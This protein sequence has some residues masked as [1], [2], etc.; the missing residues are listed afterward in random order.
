M[1]KEFVSDLRRVPPLERAQG[2]MARMLAMTTAGAVLSPALPRRPGSYTRTCA[3]SDD[4]F[5]VLLLD[6]SP[7]AVSAIHDHGGQHC[8]F[9]V[10]E[11]RLRVD[12]FDRLDSGDVPGRAIVEARDWRAL[13]PGELD[14]RS[15]P[16][17]IHRVAADAGHAVSLHVYARPLHGFSIYDERAHRCQSVRGTYDQLLSLFE[18][19]ATAR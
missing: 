17:D 19:S 6:W 11:G 18:G 1:L 16:F 10:L 5:E 15:G 3:Y 8:W 4:R 9:V 13:G 2:D 7:G 12:D 14:L